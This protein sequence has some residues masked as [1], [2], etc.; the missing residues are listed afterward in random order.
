MEIKYTPYY[1]LPKKVNLTSGNYYGAPQPSTSIDFI[2]NKKVQDKISIGGYIGQLKQEETGS[3]KKLISKKLQENPEW[4]PTFGEYKQLKTQAGMLDGN[5]NA[6][7]TLYDF[8]DLNKKYKPNWELST[9]PP[10]AFPED[11][12]K[13]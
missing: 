12:P 5:D 11:K 13:E 9:E 4:K 8:A 10:V 3:M 1:Q 7:G 6:S 2:N